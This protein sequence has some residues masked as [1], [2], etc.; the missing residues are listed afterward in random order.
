MNTKTKLISAALL[1]SLAVPALA[2]H[3]RSRDRDFD[4]QVFYDRAKVVEVLPIKEVVRVA[5]PRRDCWTEEV[6]H[7]RYQRRDV[8]GSTLV[9]AIIGGVVGHNVARGD[10]RGPATAAGT[11]I[12]AVIGNNAAKERTARE[13][14]YS[15]EQHCR[16]SEEYREEERIAGYRVTYRYQGHTYT[17]QMDR[18]PGRFVRVRIAVAA[19]E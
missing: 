2:D 13:P 11:V 7:S 1:A 18:D 3:G 15:T 5:E 17:Q 14:R 10:D 6:E 19:A 4:D 8:A 12:G 9:G 16:V